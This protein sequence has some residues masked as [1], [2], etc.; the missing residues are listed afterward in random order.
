MILVR[1]LPH[2][3][4]LDQPEPPI[5][6]AMVV[7]GVRS[8]AWALR[9]KA[10]MP[11]TP[12]HSTR[13]DAKEGMEVTQE[14]LWAELVRTL[15]ER[16]GLDPQQAEQIASVVGE[17]AQQHAADLVK[18]AAGEGVGGLLGNLGGLFGRG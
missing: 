5:R 15:Q 9:G 1:S 4:L 18:V 12:G 10:S 7:R 16:V 2:D 14:Q 13:D 6:P 11:L 17:F 3:G 8:S